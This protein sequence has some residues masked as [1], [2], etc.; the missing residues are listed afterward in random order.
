MTHCHNIH[1]A[2][3]FESAIEAFEFHLYHIATLYQIDSRPYMQSLFDF[4]DVLKD[5]VHIA[6]LKDAA[7]DAAQLL[8][9]PFQEEDDNG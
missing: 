4:K 8:N 3:V 6:A 2:R 1:Q 5:K 9:L 7:G